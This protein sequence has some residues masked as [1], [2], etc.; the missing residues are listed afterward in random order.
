MVGSVERFTAAVH[1]LSLRA[2]RSGGSAVDAAN[3]VGGKLGLVAIESSWL[4]QLMGWNVSDSAL[5]MA[6]C[7]GHGEC[8]N[9]TCFCEVRLLFHIMSR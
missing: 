7:S 1:S 3:S 4:G 9:G 2:I 5:C 8:N 6:N